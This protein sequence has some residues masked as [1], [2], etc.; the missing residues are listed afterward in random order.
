MR[1]PVIALALAVLLT[2]AGTA[3]AQRYEALTTD[4]ERL[5][6]SA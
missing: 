1:R 4:T 6:F 5:Q 3:P 2:G